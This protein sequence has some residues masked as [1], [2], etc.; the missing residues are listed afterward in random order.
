MKVGLNVGSLNDIS[1][2]AGAT[3]ICIETLSLSVQKQINLMCRPVILFILSQGTT[4]TEYLNDS[5]SASHSLSK[6][7]LEGDRANDRIILLPIT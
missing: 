6:I 1:L 3:S 5:L 4:M 7:I 2:S